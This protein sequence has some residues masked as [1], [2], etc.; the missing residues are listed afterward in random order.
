M[1]KNK[2]QLDKVEQL[3]NELKKQKDKP[4]KESKS[5]FK[6]KLRQK[7]LERIKK[8]EEKKKQKEKIKKEKEEKTKKINEEKLVKVIEL[9]KVKEEGMK[10]DVVYYES[11]KYNPFDFVKIKGLFKSVKKKKIKLNRD[12]FVLVRIKSLSKGVREF[13]VPLDAEGFVINKGRYI[14]DDTLK[15]WNATVQM[16]CFDY[17]EFINIPTQTWSVLPYEIQKSIDQ[18]NK[19]LKTGVQ[20]D[21]DI[22]KIKEVVEET[23]SIDV[24]NAVNPHVLQKY[25]KSNFVQSL[26]EGA[27]LGKMFRVMT[28]LI[29][30][31]L[32]IALISAFFSGYSSGIFHEL[33]S[34]VT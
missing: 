9:S 30:I 19:H 16:W 3:L 18:Y 33:G 29:V 1:S 32:I 15:Y 12:S 13:F 2:K 5:S 10:K 7:G 6:E 34:Q 20:A 8:K 25:L 11:F 22:E 27:S 28:V 21:V 31:T 17:Q 26:V 14:F 24:E 4:K 23:D